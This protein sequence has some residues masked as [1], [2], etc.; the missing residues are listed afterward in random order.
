MTFN[1]SDAFKTFCG[2]LRFSDDE[3][4]KI[5]DRYHSI[6]RTHFIIN[7]QFL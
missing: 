7:G 3:L 6:T 5:I 2:E 4:S 1:V